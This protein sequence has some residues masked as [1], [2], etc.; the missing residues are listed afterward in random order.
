MKADIQKP[1]GLLQPLPVPLGLWHT[2]G[3]GFVS[4]LPSLH[5]KTVICTVE[6]HFTTISHFLALPALPTASV[7]EQLFLD[8]VVRLHGLLV[9]IVSDR[10]HQFVSKF[11]SGLCRLLRIDPALSLGY[12]PQTNGQS[13]RANQVVELFLRLYMDH[14]QKDWALLPMA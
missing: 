3:I 9:K 14:H 12:H 10:G 5:G 4:D 13:E 6:D 8:Q 2:V 11:W 7:L 1:Q